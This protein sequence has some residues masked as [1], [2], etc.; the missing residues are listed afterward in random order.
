MAQSFLQV[1]ELAIQDSS[2]HGTVVEWPPT[3]E[4]E[5][6]GGGVGFGN[7]E[8]LKEHEPLR[9]S[10]EDVTIPPVLRI[11]HPNLAAKSYERHR[12]DPLFLYKV[13]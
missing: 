4:V 6:A 7:V 8:D 11:L 1:V 12:R 3:L 10:Q 2:C 5:T 13:R 9:L